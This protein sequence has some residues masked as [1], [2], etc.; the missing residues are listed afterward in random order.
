MPP[1]LAAA[2]KTNSGFSSQKKAFTLC[3]SLKSNSAEVLVIIFVNPF[4]S[5]LR[6]IAEPTIPR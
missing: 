6:I 2:K 5:R 1:T 4:F 3:E